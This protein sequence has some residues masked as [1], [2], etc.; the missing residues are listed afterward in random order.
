MKTLYMSSEYIYINFKSCKALFE[1]SCI[2]NEYLLMRVR[3]GTRFWTEWQQ[4]LLQSRLHSDMY[5]EAPHYTF[6]Q[7]AYYL[8]PQGQ[9]NLLEPVFQITS[10][11]SQGSEFVGLWTSPIVEYS[12][13]KRTRRFGNWICFRPQAKGE[14][15]NLLGPLRK[16]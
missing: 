8:K 14:S 10:V 12:T 16:V 3:E 11:Y 9:N 4:I 6:A 5:I 13:N 15:P 2:S 7:A 1:T